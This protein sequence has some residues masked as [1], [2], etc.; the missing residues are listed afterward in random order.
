M[1]N[2]MSMVV[3]SRE[4]ESII[5]L[6]LA[7]GIDVDRR[8]V[9]VGDYILS[10]E[11]AVERKTIKDFIASMFNGRLFE[12]AENLKLTYSKPSI[13]LEGD[14]MKELEFST[15][16]KAFWGAL[17]TLEVDMGIPVISTPTHTHTAELLYTFAK[18]LQRKKI[19]DISLHKP[20]LM[21][22]KDWQI[23]VVA[24]LPSIGRE[25]STRLL[26]KFRT[27]RDVFR[28]NVND[29]QEVRGIGRVKADRISHLID[30]KYG[31]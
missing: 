22:E 28:A 19:K 14:I 15:N 20:K 2:A 18:R 26:R 1:D 13:I 5:S 3:D 24:S 7:L 4:P 6:L 12:Q 23:Y 25:L 29:L 31:E 16:T 10:S 27:V 21:T 30:Q 11:C 9:G 8:M 17:I